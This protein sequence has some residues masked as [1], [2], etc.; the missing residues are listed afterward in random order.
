MGIPQTD[1]VASPTMTDV[2][3]TWHSPTE[4]QWA[5]DTIPPLPGHQSKAKIEDRGTP[6]VDSTTSPAM[7]DAEDT[8]PGPMEA[9]PMDEN[10][11]S[12][13]KPDTETKKDLPTTQAASPAK[14]GNQVGTTAGSVDES[15]GLPIPSVHPIKEK[16]CVLALTATMEILSLEAPSVVVGCQ[17]ATVEELPEEDLVE[18]HP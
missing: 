6:P 16:Q 4:T 17:G 3:A 8:Q 10:T 7:T 5:D 13:A 14:L 2:G 9:L 18:G 12:L 15:A 11:I 1:S